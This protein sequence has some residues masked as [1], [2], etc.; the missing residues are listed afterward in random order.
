[1]ETRKSGIARRAVLGI[2]L[3]C[4]G[5]LLLAENIGIINTPVSHIIFS[6]Q[7]LLIVIGSLGLINRRGVHPTSIILIGIGVFF[8]IPDIFNVTFDV[9]RLFLPFIFVII[10]VS[11]LF[12]SHDH[13]HWRSKCRAD[14]RA[15]RYRRYS[16]NWREDLNTEQK[17]ENFGSDYIDESNI[18][19]GGD[20]K[21][22]SK[23]F[24]GGKIT[25][26]FGGGTYNFLDCELAEG[27]NVLEMVNIF[28]GAKLIIP[29]DWVIHLDV[30]AVFGGFSDKRHRMSPPADLTKKE[31]Y[32]TGIAIFGG[33][34][35]KSM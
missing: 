5:V 7:M 14:W 32:I 35:I 1:M 13:N 4:F 21:I 33:G 6:W 26:V 23:A 28:G 19:N 12:H 34:E 16:Y 8:L 15:H 3:M 20:K 18:F 17:P 25:N 24:H 30:A 10:G 31:L 9:G 29:S 11:I 22:I 2:I 27:K